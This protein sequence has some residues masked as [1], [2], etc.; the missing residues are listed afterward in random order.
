[1]ARWAAGRGHP[2]GRAAV[3]PRQSW[4]PE[5]DVRPA[6][7]GPDDPVPAAQRAAAGLLAQIGMALWRAGRAPAWRRRRASRCTA[8]RYKAWSRPSR[9]RRSGLRRRLPRTGDLALRK[10]HVYGTVLVGIAT[11]KVI[12]VLADREAGTVADWLRAHPGARVICRD[13]AGAYAEGA[14]TGAPQAVQVAGRWHLWHNL[15]EYAEKTSRCPWRLPQAA[16]SRR[17][18]SD[19]G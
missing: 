15:G 7:G 12:G 8:A 6:G 4:L 1:M 5:D 11:G 10:G 19:H 13:R 3:V 2:P 18:G 14:R 16:R 9:N 17:A